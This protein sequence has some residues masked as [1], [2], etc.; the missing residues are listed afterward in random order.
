MQTDILA[1]K[2]IFR[3]YFCQI[4]KFCVVALEILFQTN[5]SEKKTNYLVFEDVNRLAKTCLHRNEK[6]M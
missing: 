4:N 3:L 1:L 5:L 2:G 6:K